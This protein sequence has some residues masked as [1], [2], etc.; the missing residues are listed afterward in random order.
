MDR[1]P[2]ISVVTVS[3]NSVQTIE[4]TLASV[5]GQT[6]RNIEHI[7]IDGASTDGTVELLQRHRGTIAR[8][9]SEPDAG[10]YDAMNKGIRCAR[11]TWI[12][13]LNADD[14]YSDKDALARAVDVLEPSRTNYFAIWRQFGD[15]RRDLQDWRYRRW[16]LFISAFLPHPGLIVARAQ[17]EVA[18]LY[19]ASYRIAADH[20]MI[21]RLTARWRGLRHP[22]PLVTMQQ[23]G[24]SEANRLTAL[25]EFQE[26]TTRHGLP[27]SASFGICLLKQFWW[28]IRS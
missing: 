6:Y 20:D 5:G 10:I 15:A 25:R 16:H 7:V 13:L 18:G 1:N 28:K 27:R 19:E 17:Y 22:W 24:Y 11:G 2:L 23:G 4:R 3:Y 21:L 12:H 26:V 8:R 14:F 9:V